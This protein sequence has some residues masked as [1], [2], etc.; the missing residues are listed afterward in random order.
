M[1]RGWVVEVT[2]LQKKYSGNDLVGQAKCDRSCDS[3]T[4]GFLG[5]VRAVVGGGYS[6]SAA[7]KEGKFGLLV[8]IYC[9]I[10]M[11]FLGDHLNLPFS[12]FI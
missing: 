1:L 8:E 5:R 2:F 7:W 10:H 6:H 11:A 3:D 9:G 4:I 12:G